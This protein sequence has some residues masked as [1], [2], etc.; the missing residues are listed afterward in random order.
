MVVK[1]SHAKHPSSKDS[2]TQHL[3]DD[4][5]R[6]GDEESPD[7]D[8][9]QV[10][11]HQETERSQTGA[12]RQG[13]G[14][15]HDDFGRRRVPPEK[16]H[17]GPHESHRHQTEIEG[18]VDAIDRI[19]TKLPV[20]NYGQHAKTESP[21]SGGQSIE[22]VGQVHGIRRRHDDQDGEQYPTN[23]SEIPTGEREPREG[24]VGRR[25]HP[26]D[27]EN[28]EHSRDEQQS[29]EFG[30]LV[31]PQISRVSDG[32]VVIAKAEQSRSHRHAHREQASA[33]EDD[34]GAY[35]AH[36]VSEH[37]RTDNDHPAHG[38]GTGLGVMG[39]GTVLTNQL[40]ERSVL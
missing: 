37:G 6:L 7:H 35:V 1:R 39:R 32:Q 15:S 24:K 29:N 25:V 31:E 17:A 13:P 18:R 28:G 9:E 20:A 40:A 10:E 27:S 21:R 12:Y 3:Q 19:V 16:A 11:V 2:K 5:C 22:A 4:R 14:V 23:T 26:V 30:E 36:H 34:R 38:G 8:E 33:R